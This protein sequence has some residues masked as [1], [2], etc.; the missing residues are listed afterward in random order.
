MRF[1]K[2]GSDLNSRTLIY[3]KAYLFTFK[4]IIKFGKIYLKIFLEKSFMKY[5]YFIKEFLDTPYSNPSFVIFTSKN[6]KKK[7]IKNSSIVSHICD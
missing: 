2:R 5:E 6:E 1:I 7:S 4:T 3:F